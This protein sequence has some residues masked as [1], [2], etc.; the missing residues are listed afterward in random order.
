MKEAALRTFFA[1][2]GGSRV[3]PNMEC[4][5]WQERGHGVGFLQDLGRSFVGDS[6]NERVSARA[7]WFLLAPTEN[8]GTGRVGNREGIAEILFAISQ[9]VE[10]QEMERAMR[11]NNEV[12]PLE[13]WAQR[14]DEL[15][16]ERFQMTVRGAQ[17]RFFK[18]PDVFVAHAKLGELKSQQL[19]K[20][21]G[22]GKHGHGLNLDFLARDDGG[23]E[24]V[25]SHKV[26]NEG[27]V[28]RKMRLQLGEGKIR[29]G[30]QG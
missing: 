26:F 27:R 7:G 1:K 12:L 17:E 9:S 30:L 25:P 29:G 4:R 13:K 3:V 20:M 24:S 2:Q 8:R 15:A 16:I 6:K 22:S 10:R 21:S 23:D 11:N 5:L 19:Q 18:S 28:L 14:R